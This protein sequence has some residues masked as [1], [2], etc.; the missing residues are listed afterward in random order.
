MESDL[1]QPMMLARLF[2]L[3]KHKSPEWPPDDLKE[4]LAHQL[5]TPLPD[6]LQPTS[7]LIEDQTNAGAHDRLREDAPHS[8]R[9]ILLTDTP[10][11]KL[12]IKMKD[13]VKGLRHTP[14]HPLPIEI[15]TTL[16]Y[17]CISTAWMHTGSWITSADPQSIRSGLAWLTRQ[18]WMDADLLALY[19]HTLDRMSQA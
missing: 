10:P 11:I 8:F 2:E 5:D 7:T 1:F 18:P 4:I 13:Y 16:Y 17:A 14:D 15:S 3:G 9:H 12:L 6:N 19:R